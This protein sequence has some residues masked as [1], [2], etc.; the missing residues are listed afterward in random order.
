MDSELNSGL[1]M[2]TAPRT[3]G[4]L[5][6]TTLGN[7]SPR[8]SIS[9]LSGEPAAGTH[10]LDLEAQNTSHAPRPRRYS[11]EKEIYPDMTEEERSLKRERT[12]EELKRVYSKRVEQEGELDPPDDAGSLKGVDPELITW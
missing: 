1:H 2:E 4:T 9:V 3:S 6:A 12:L 7:S 10:Y 11:S 5:E 8:S